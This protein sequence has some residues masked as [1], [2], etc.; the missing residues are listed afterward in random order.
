MKHRAELEKMCGRMSADVL[1]IGSGLAGLLLA[2]KLSEAGAS[3]ILASKGL[4]ADSNTRMAQGGLAVVMPTSD[5]DSL[6]SHMADTVKAGAGL[7]DEK[8]ARRIVEEGPALVRELRDLG[9]RFDVSI[10]GRLELAREG[11]HSH[12]RV[13]HNKD[14]TGR[15]ISDALLTHVN[16]LPNLLA[17]QNT[18]AVDLLSDGQRCQGAVVLFQGK[19]TLIAAGQVVLATGGV[20]QVFERTTNPAVA[21]GDGLA[22]AY[23]AGARLADMEFVQFHPTALLKPGSP[24]YLLSEALRGA[25]AVLLDSE[26]RRFLSRF[27][28]DA[29]LATRDVVARAMVSVMHEQGSACVWLDMRP[30]GATALTTRFPNIVERCRELGVDPVTQPVPV[31]PAAHYFMGGIKTDGDG[32]T[33][34]PGLFAIGECAST[35]LHGANRLASNSLLEAGVMALRVAREI[36][37]RPSPV[38][39]SARSSTGGEKAGDCLDLAPRAVPADLAQFRRLMFQEA[40]LCRNQAGLSRLLAQLNVSCVRALPETRA[41]CEAANM[42]VVA[43]LIAAAA[44]SRCESRG[45]HFRSDYSAQDDRGFL[46]RTCQQRGELTWL[47]VGLPEPAVAATPVPPAA[48]VVS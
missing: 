22:L 34:L 1:I 42:L 12:A 14:A 26:G 3:V 20:G 40:G 19:P 4:L 15:A 17:L 23:R 39:A 5:L 33:S 30:I 36:N 35:G 29:E 16:S 25:G 31:S 38:P 24:A 2:F 43:E 45:A 44:Q 47:A 28:L 9:V 32:R 7:V 21:T 11:G 41:A 10:S 46:R 37:C 6:E 27:H 13:L 8:V 18:V 48:T